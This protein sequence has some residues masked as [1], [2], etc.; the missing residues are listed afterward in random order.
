MQLLIIN[1]MFAVNNEIF[2]YCSFISVYINNSNF[3]RL[4]QDSSKN[5]DYG[6]LTYILI[7]FLQHTFSCDL[8]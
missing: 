7:Q 4:W 3:A 6:V 5:P 8:G 1:V 2:G